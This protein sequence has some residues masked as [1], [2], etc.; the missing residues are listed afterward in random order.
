MCDYAER[1]LRMN[2]N[3]KL[4]QAP[5]TTTGAVIMPANPMRHLIL[6]PTIAANTLFYQ[7]GDTPS[8]VGINGYAGNPPQCFLSRDDLGDVITF[9]VRM[10]VLTTTAN[11]RFEEISYNAQNYD[12]YM[13]RLYD[14]ITD[15]SSW[16]P[17]YSRT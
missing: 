13:R 16:G 3:I 14:T 15:P 9:P 5:L 10:W 11:V 7:F 4:I 17:D 2:M 8:G 1:Y 12:W 6:L